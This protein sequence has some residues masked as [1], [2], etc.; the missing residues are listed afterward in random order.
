MPRERG[1]MAQVQAH[2]HEMGDEG[3]P[4]TRL[5]NGAAA[6]LSLGLLVGVGYWGYKTV[7]RDVSGVPVIRAAEGEMRVRPETPGGTPAPHQGLAVNVIAAVGSATRV[8]DAVTL[9]PRAADVTEEDLATAA[10]PEKLAEQAAAVQRAAQE[11]EAAEKAAARDKILQAA[12]E[13]GDVDDLSIKALAEK[14]AAE[15]KPAPA[16]AETAEAGARTGTLSSVRPRQRPAA[17]IQAGFKPAAKPGAIPAVASV[18]AAPIQ[19]SFAAPANDVSIAD[20]T[21]GTP[22]AQLGA[23]DSVETAEK[24]WTRLYGGFEDYMEGKNR[25]I[26]R[27]TSGGRVFYRLRVAGFSD[28]S[29][30]RRFCAAFVAQDAECIPVIAK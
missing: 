5:I 21:A 29:D 13:T 30:A 27:A 25:V 18:T 12:A 16:L 26:Q 7:A 9:A 10:L 1:E 11:A 23:F 24:D 28:L 4:V 17:L 2:P 8:P 15:V 19:A 6:A 20:I 14:V 22:L 3:I